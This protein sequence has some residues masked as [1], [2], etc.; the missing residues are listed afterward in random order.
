MD[1][2]ALAGGG[3]QV[4]PPV[5]KPHPLDDPFQPETR[6]ADVRGVE[7]DAPVADVDLQAIAVLEK[8]DADPLAAAVPA[9]V[10][11]PFLDDAVDGV[12][13]GGTSRSNSTRL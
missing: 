8:F 1:P 4:E 9:G 7:A 11:Q 5:E 3:L 6:V 13:Q 12:L 2:R 10:G